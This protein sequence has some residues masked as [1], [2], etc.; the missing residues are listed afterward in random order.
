MFN[1]FDT[2]RLGEFGIQTKYLDRKSDLVGDTLSGRLLFHPQLQIGRRV[3]QTI[4]VFVMYVF[5]FA[6]RTSKRFGHEHAVLVGFSTTAE[7]Q[8]PVS[9]RMHVA[10]RIYWRSFSASVSAVTR[11][12]S[13]SSIVARVPAVF[14]AAKTTFFGFAAE[15]AP[16]NWNWTTRATAFVHRTSVNV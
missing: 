13:L 14:G 15:F 3:V 12:E 4:T 11:A 16:E 2:S 8:P 5:A 6:Q 7:M 10:V 9:R 1:Q